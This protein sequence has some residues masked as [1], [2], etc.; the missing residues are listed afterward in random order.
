M[1]EKILLTAEEITSL[2][3]LRNKTSE[4]I[5]ALGSTELQ[6]QELTNSKTQI[7]G[8]FAEIKQEQEKL[9]T[10]LQNKYGKGMVD[11]ETGEFAK[12]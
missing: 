1:E 11:L 10:I 5:S 4:V 7:L 12:S 8:K 9:G 2:K 3:E 6:I